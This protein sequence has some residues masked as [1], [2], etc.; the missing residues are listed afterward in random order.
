MTTDRIERVI[1]LRAPPRRVWRA[2]SDATEF[3]H[4]FGITFQERFVPGATVHGVISGTKVDPEA[5][6]AMESVVGVPLVITIERMEP[7]KV[8]SFRW[9]PHASDRSV[10]YSEEPTTLVVFE[11]EAVPEGTRLK[12]TESGFDRVPSHR[13]RAAFEANSAGWDM[14]MA[15]VGKHLDRAP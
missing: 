8:F 11:L 13:R 10:D 14:Q 15:L 1:V 12:V 6:R 2:L 5:A 7:E 9:H 3:G 4:W